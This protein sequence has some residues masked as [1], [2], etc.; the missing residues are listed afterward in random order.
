M[1]EKLRAIVEAERTRNRKAAEARAERLSRAR[2]EALRIAAELARIDSRVT[3]VWLFGSV[4]TGRPGRECFDIDLAVRGGDI[5]SLYA[6]MPE[7]EFDVDLIDLDSVS[8][9]FRNMVIRRGEKVY[10]AD[11]VD[12]TGQRNT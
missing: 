3:E 9:R 7:S 5:V 8:D 4:A 12:S 11:A 10:G 6:R 1:D 2:S